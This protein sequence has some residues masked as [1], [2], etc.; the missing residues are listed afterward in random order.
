MIL[1][2]G[3]KIVVDP[4]PDAIVVDPQ[5]TLASLVSLEHDQV[6]TNCLLLSMSSPEAALF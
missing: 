2:L 1:A 5:S 6:A 3:D 4:V